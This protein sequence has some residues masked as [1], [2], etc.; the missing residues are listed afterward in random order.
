MTVGIIGLGFMGAT[1][2]LA[3]TRMPGVEIAAVC[4][5]D[6]TA[7][8]GEFSRQ[9]GNL[10]LTFP[11][12]P[13]HTAAKYKDW[14]LLVEDP[15]VDAV[16]ICAPS[17]VHCEMAIA[18]LRAGKHV[19][20]EKPMA[21]NLA[22]CDRM[23]EA[24]V[25]SGK[26]M[27]IAHVLRFWPAYEY[28]KLWVHKQER[29]TYTRATFRRCAGLPNWS[30][31]LTD[32]DRSGGAIVDLLIHDIDQAILLFGRPQS[33]RAQQ[34]AGASDAITA[35]LLYRDGLVVKVEGGWF[36][37][38][39]PFSMSFH[40]ETSTWSIEFKENVLTESRSGVVSLPDAD[41]Y[42]K[43]LRYFL[44]CCEANR[45]PELCPPRESRTAVG[46]ASLLKESRR[47][48]GEVIACEL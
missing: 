40:L 3:Y 20:C 10:G 24:A 29:S 47:L 26:Q 8:N 19:I 38:S 16:D 33:V 1:H 41:P 43:Q 31:W 4:S 34:V 6:D 21:L 28:L 48:E 23:I 39:V 7:L 35:N 15:S 11:D 2:A 13:L 25:E 9:G 18:A 12:V 46:I 14:R 5:R 32:N 44:D 37:E 27:M 42:G 30:R 45:S 36:D 17:D 22:D